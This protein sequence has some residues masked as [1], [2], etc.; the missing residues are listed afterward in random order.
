M[1][2]VE[3]PPPRTRPGRVRAFARWI[4][5]VLIV[6]GALMI[7]DAA[8]TLL[9][10]EPLTAI[11]GHFKQ[12]G[13]ADRLADLEHDQQLDANQLAALERLKTD[14]R[15]IAFLARAFAADVKEGEPIGRISSKRMGIDYVVVQGTAAADL[16]KGP[17]HYPDTA[18]PG[19][20]RTTA[21]AGHRTTYLAPFRHIDSL[22]KGDVIKL[23]MTYATFTYRVEKHRIVDPGD[24][25]VV[26]SRGYDRL[27]L[28]ACHPLYSAAKRYIIFARL[29]DERLT[30]AG[31]DA[32]QASERLA[33]AQAAEQPTR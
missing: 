5:S 3:A 33:K 1:S 32:K 30:G 31:L 26:R 2:T 28:S 6:A 7:A 21:I 18:F 14:H 24:Y 20:G 12:G 16:R 10:Q 11:Y 19:L 9:W 8:I 15:R 22:K 23:R 25:G 17:G 27:V 13:L 4:S 29:V